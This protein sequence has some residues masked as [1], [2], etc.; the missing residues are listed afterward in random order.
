VRTRTD[1]KWLTDTLAREA[2]SSGGV[3]HDIAQEAAT[4]TLRALGT[5]DDPPL[6][7]ERRA[8]SYF[9]AVVRRKLVRRPSARSAVARIVAAGVIA[10]LMDSGRSA[11][12]AWEAFERGWACEL[13]PEVVE[14]C[15]G[16]LCA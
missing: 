7:M 13:P 10:D 5:T 3:P 2:E 4:A 6:L 12:E 11:N 8:R 16:R 1:I 9:S 15:R 14:E